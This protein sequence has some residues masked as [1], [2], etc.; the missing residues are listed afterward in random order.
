MIRSVEAGPSAEERPLGPRH[1][2]P[3]GSDDHHDSTTPFTFI[4]FGSFCRGHRLLEVSDRTVQ[5]DPQ[6]FDFTRFRNIGRARGAVRRSAHATHSTRRCALR[7]GQLIAVERHGMSRGFLRPPTPRRP[8]R[9]RL[10]SL[11][12]RERA[13]RRHRRRGRH[14]GQ[15]M[16]DVRVVG[17]GRRR[18]VDIGFG[19]PLGHVRTQ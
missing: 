10:A 16:N 5:S 12:V 9:N 14:E 18:T 19:C 13:G 2:S 11:P 3:P 6:R 8:W 15:G 7:G 1:R 17:A 4:K